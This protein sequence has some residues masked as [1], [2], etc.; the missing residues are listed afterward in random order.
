MRNFGILIYMMEK[1]VTK[2]NV[3]WIS[4]FVTVVLF[5]LDQIGTETGA[6]CQDHMRVTGSQLV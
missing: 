4:G 5:I 2:K 6:V 1:L 3:L